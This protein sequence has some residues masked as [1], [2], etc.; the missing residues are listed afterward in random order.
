MK[1]IQ[2]SLLFAS[3]LSAGA[4]VTTIIPAVSNVAVVQAATKCSSSSKI[5]V[6]VAKAQL[7]NEKG[8]KLSRCLTKGKT[9]TPKEKT[10]I[11]GQ[12]YYKVGKDEF[13]KASD[14]SLEK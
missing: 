3:L 8:K 13:V 6:K 11:K 5:K 4:S 2:K 10:S 7:Y 12:K 9:C 1:L 14:V